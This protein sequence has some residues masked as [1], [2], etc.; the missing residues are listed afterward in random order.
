MSV[1]AGMPGL[2]LPADPGFR[3]ARLREARGGRL[4][5]GSIGAAALVHAAVIAAVI[6]H[7]P[8]LF[9]V[10]PNERPP[11]PVT[12]VQEVPAPKAQPAPPPPQDHERVSGP[13]NE[14]T[15]APNSGPTHETTAAPS[16]AETASQEAPATPKLP[17]QD[18][19]APTVVPIPKPAENT[20]QRDV[21]PN[22]AKRENAPNSEPPV[23]DRLPGELTQEGDE[24]LN[25][26]YQLV[27]RHRTYPAAA[28]SLYLAPRGV[29]VY[30][31]EVRADGSLQSV[32][33]IRSAGATILDQTAIGMIR[34]AAPFPPLPSDFT[35]PSTFRATIPIYPLS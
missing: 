24:Y 31:L 20:K 35:H 33:I 17:E 28:S 7:W 3:E 12:L 14:T 2:L 21:K 15:T 30:R 4:R 5:R 19:P 34:S 29:G 16:T 6:V 8:A 23:P 10:V 22:L 32:E 11:I 18:V 27:E 13:T 26:L 25:K 9:P 1:A